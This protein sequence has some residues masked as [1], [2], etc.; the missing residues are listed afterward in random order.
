MSVRTFALALVA[1]AGLTTVAPAGDFDK[2][3]PEKSQLYVHVNM[4]KLFTSPMVRKVVPMVF[5]TSAN[6]SRS[7]SR[8]TGTVRPRSVLTATPML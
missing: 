7:Q 6:P 1:F 4:P 3:L 8:K 2:Y 5:S